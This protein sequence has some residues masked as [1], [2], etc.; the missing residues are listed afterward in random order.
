MEVRLCSTGDK[1]EERHTSITEKEN[2]YNQQ[3]SE[4]T[5]SSDNPFINK[6]EIHTE[7]LGN[8]QEQRPCRRDQCS[9]Y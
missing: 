3:M 7:R 8:H 2:N 5:V 9:D 1:H 4:S 6:N